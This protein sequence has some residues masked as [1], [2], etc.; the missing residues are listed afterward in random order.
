MNLEVNSSDIKL[1]QIEEKSKSTFNQSVET[2]DQYELAK[3]TELNENI[4]NQLSYVQDYLLP[5]SEVIDD[6]SSGYE[7]L[8]REYDA[9]EIDNRL[10]NTHIMDDESVDDYHELNENVFETNGLT[11]T[12][13]GNDS[14]T[15][16]LD[17][18]Y[19]FSQDLLSTMNL[20]E[21]ESPITNFSKT[22]IPIKKNLNS[23]PLE[24][25][26]FV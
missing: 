10:S 1:H 25:L 23:M 20:S 19:N 21:N 17:F 22:E 5:I 18:K 4:Q 14:N 7:G 16:T 2:N 8:F 3:K 26:F 13:S 11:P 6:G 24:D 12:V 15:N 9:F